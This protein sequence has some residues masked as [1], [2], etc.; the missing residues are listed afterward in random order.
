VFRYGRDGGQ[1]FHLPTGRVRTAG[2]PEALPSLT[3]LDG[4]WRLAQSS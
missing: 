2:T 1:V 3:A 4:Q